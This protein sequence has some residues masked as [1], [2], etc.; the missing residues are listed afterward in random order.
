MSHL[1]YEVVH[2]V[3]ERVTDIVGVL[4]IHVLPGKPPAE[5]LQHGILDKA[6]S[7][8]RG[9][10]VDVIDK[11]VKDSVHLHRSE[12]STKL[13]ARPQVELLSNDSGSGVLVQ[14][15]A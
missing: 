14:G 8:C 11:P 1:V 12:V 6:F 3:S 13:V 7:L 5:V 4:V 2:E 15:I 10:V 9:L